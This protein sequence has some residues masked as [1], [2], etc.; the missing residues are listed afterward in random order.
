MAPACL[1]PLVRAL[2]LPLLNCRHR[3]P[4]CALGIARALLNEPDGLIL[5]EITNGLDE[6]AKAG[7]MA[8][9]SDLS[10]RRLVLAISHDRPAFAAA[11]P[12]CLELTP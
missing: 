8:T 7:L 3:L 12:T 5:D 6:E 10:R 11:E 2:R 1:A 4:V 9:V